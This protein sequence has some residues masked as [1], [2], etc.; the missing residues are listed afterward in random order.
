MVVYVI[1]Y[2]FKIFID[3]VFIKNEI[4]Q[5]EALNDFSLEVSKSLVID[6]V[7]ELTIHNIKEVI[8][9]ND[10]LIALLNEDNKEYVIYP[11]KKYFSYP[12]INAAIDSVEVKVNA[13]DYELAKKLLAANDKAE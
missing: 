11:D 13:E 6:D 2:F 9:V 8:N 7:L 12:S 1:F 4:K 3:H 10:I 5:N